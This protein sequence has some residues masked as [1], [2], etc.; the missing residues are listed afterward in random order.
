MKIKTALTSVAVA[1]SLLIAQS[2]TAQ[3]NDSTKVASADS[4]TAKGATAK[5]TVRH[6]EQYGDYVADGE[7]RTLYMYTKDQQQK[8][9]EPAESHC[10]LLCE[11][12]WPPYTAEQKPEVGQGLQAS[13]AG[14]IKGRGGKMHV[15]YG[16][17]PLYYYV[18]DKSPGQVEGQGKDREWY[19]VT[20]DG[21]MSLKGV[22]EDAE[23]KK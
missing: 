18:E 16:G 15:T 1:A 19:L 8:G 6:S 17:W 7:G 10:G 2:L 20:P 21:K 4:D 9:N 11:R 13:L 3:D 14:A 5:L 23:E 22:K 12:A